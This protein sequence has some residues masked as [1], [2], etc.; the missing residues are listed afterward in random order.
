M[1]T[2]KYRYFATYSNAYILPNLFYVKNHQSLKKLMYLIIGMD[3]EIMVEK[4]DSKWIL[5]KISNVTYD[6]FNTELP[7]N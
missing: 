2:G 7:M 6:V 4:P 1:E 5:F 3:L